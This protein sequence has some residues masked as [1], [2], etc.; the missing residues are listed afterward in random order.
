MLPTDALR[1]LGVALDA[2]GFCV[3]L[4]V[5]HAA[6][7]FRY[8]IVRVRLSESSGRATNLPIS[9]RTAARLLAART[10]AQRT[11]TTHTEG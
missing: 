3:L 10:S 5:A 9:R 2:D 4:R 1:P 11:T 6:D 8:E 7:V